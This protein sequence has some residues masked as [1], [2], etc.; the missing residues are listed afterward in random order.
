MVRSIAAEAATYMCVCVPSIAVWKGVPSC[1]AVFRRLRGKDASCRVPWR[2]RFNKSSQVTRGSVGSD[3]LGML[4][5]GTL[6]TDELGALMVPHAYSI[7]L[8]ISISFLY[9]PRLEG[10]GEM[11]RTGWHHRNLVTQCHDKIGTIR[12]VGRTVKLRAAVRRW[13]LSVNS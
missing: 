9:P 10:G 3:D 13:C 7:V 6:D 1:D 8:N 12:S 5:K 4:D 11:K 2:S